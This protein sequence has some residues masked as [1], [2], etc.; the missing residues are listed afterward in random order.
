MLR[1]KTKKLPT[2]KHLV[3]KMF[4]SILAGLAVVIFSIIIG[5]VGYHYYYNKNANDNNQGR[6]REDSRLDKAYLT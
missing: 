2:Q 4:K 6:A 3:S 5:M 1:N